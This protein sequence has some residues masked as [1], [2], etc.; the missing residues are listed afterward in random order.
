WVEKR[1]ASSTG[2]HHPTD[3]PRGHWRTR[4]GRAIRAPTVSAGEESMD[5]GMTDRVKPL[6]EKVRRMVE[7]EIAPLDAEFHAE[8]GKGG[9]RFAYTPRMTEIMEGL[10]AK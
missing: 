7:E 8:I 1:D 2:R 6:V 5:L 3:D 4:P 9:D 10:K